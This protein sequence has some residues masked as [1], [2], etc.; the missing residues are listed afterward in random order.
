MKLFLGKAPNVNSY[1]QIDDISM[2]FRV[3]A[4]TLAYTVLP[5]DSGTFFTTEGATAAVTFTLPAPTATNAE[6]CV[7]FFYCAENLA[8]TVASGTA[9]L[10]IAINDVTADSVAF[11]T[12]SLMTGGCVMIV[13]DGAKWFSCILSDGNTVTVATS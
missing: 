3:V 12:T 7:F 13:G 5:S 1:G 10:L 8:M 9:D 11:S 2:K 6:G 4:K